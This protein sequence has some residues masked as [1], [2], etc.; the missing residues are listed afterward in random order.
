MEGKQ[1]LRLLRLKDIFEK[2]T[3]E[4][5]GLSVKDIQNELLSFDIKVDRKTLYT[6]M[7]LLRSYGLDI[8]KEKL[9]SN[10]VYY[11]GNRYFELPEL[12]LM[13]D[14][15]QSS[16]FITE[17]KTRKLIQKIESLASEHE[18]KE[19][20]R[21]V[22][23]SGRVKSENESIYYIVNDIHEAI[24]SNKKITFKYYEIYGN[25]EKRLRHNGEAYVVSPWLLVWDNQKYYLIGYDDRT[26]EIHHYRVDKM[27]KVAISDEKRAGKKIFKDLDV[28]QY[29]NRMFGMYSGELKTVELCVEN[30]LTG[31]IY[32]RF[33]MDVKCWVK[34][35]N[36]TGFEIEVN[37]S[38]QFIGWIIALGNGVKI[39]GPTDVVNMM[40]QTLTDRMELYTKK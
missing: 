32:D 8:L 3:D 37:V 26:Q 24:N 39:V 21:Q 27:V 28:V 18:G 30:S 11:I 4:Q 12:K 5:H 17:K 16:K 10:V 2:K 25:K 20:N 29:S 1:R 19:L 13:V 38:G 35:D 15:V 36:H 23:V 22:F 14:A 40:R 31:V 33:G 7:D 9:G 34:D 6:D